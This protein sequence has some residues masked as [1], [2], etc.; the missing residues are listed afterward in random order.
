[1]GRFTQ[2]VDETVEFDGDTVSFTL[3]R[4][5]NKHMLV[6]APVLA[7]LPAENALARTARLVQAADGILRECVTNWKGPVDANGRYM[8]F[9]EVLAESYFLSLMDEVLG[10]LLKVSVMQEVDAKKSPATPPAVLSGASVE[11]SASPESLPG[12]GT[13]PS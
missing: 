8:T 10:R 9:D 3:R 5:Q 6:L 4:L 11:A 7:A 13:T 1:M 2:A 12:G